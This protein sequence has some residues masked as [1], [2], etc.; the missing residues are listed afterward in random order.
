MFTELQTFIEEL[1]KRHMD[2]QKGKTSRQLTRRWVDSETFCQC[3]VP[4]NGP[5]WVVK[6]PVRAD[7]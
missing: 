6:A 4:K 3:P 7:C 2:K 1:D 5:S